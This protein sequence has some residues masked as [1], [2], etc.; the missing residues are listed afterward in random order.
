MI[1]WSPGTKHQRFSGLWRVDDLRGWHSVGMAITSPWSSAPGD[2]PWAAFGPAVVATLILHVP[3]QIWFLN[4]APFPH[5][6]PGFQ[7]SFPL[8]AWSSLL[9]AHQNHLKASQVM[10]TWVAPHPV[11]FDGSG[12]QQGHWAF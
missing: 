4:L 1:V 5:Q 12:V 11:G 8:M 2:L 10:D 6:A 9:A 3:G 7:A